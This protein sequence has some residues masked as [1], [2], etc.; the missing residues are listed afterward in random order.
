MKSWYSITAKGDSLAEISIYEEIGMFGVTAKQFLED[1]KSVGA[2]RILLRINSNGGDVFEGL[3]IY[4]RLRE[5]AAGVEVRVDGIAASMASVIAMAGAPVKM[6]EGAFLMLHNP[7]G[8]VMGNAEDMRETAELLDKVR[9]S[10]VTA[11]ERK[12]GLSAAK[13]CD[14]LDKETWLTA[15]EAKALGFVDEVTEPLKLAARFDSRRFRNPPPQL[16]PTAPTAMNPLRT[17]IL[18]VLAISDPADSPLSDET[19]TAK[20]NEKMGTL[21]ALSA[22]RDQLKAERDNLTAQFTELTVAA[23]KAKSD[24]TAAQ[25]SITSLLAERDEAKKFLATASGNITR[26]EALCGVKGVNA[27]AAVPGM[28]ESAA[29]GHVF[30]QWCA[31]TGPA[32]QKLWN[33]HKEAIRAEATARGI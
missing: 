3:A 21:T 32:K 15:A 6:A 16:S 25:T 27:S 33:E 14:M 26:L 23:N 31:A 24:L 29:G 7:G 17:S 13:I 19:L 30:D 4:N 28:E 8:L 18:A 10:L 20:L 2:R 12:S 11:Y 1:M 5:H 9:G 22:E